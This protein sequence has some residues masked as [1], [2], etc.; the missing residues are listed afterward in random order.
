[1]Q[2]NLQKKCWFGQSPPQSEWK[3]ST[4]NH[5]KEGATL[6]YD[7]S[8]IQTSCCPAP[9][10]DIP[11]WK[12]ACTKFQCILNVA[13]LSSV[14]TSIEFSLLEIVYSKGPSVQMAYVII[15]CLM[16]DVSVQMVVTHKDFSVLCT[17]SN[18]A[19]KMLQTLCEF[20]CFFRKNKYNG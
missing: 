19:R 7:G 3:L 6:A 8:E 20:V 2:S 5:N 10:T 4:A 9:E 15:Q 12:H 14:K 16:N 13:S 11:R 1:M 17:K 18:K